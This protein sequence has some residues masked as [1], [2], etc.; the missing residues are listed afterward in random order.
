MTPTEFEGSQEPLFMFEKLDLFKMVV[1]LFSESGFI[2]I[3][4]LGELE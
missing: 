2:P 4:R 1:I 3:Q